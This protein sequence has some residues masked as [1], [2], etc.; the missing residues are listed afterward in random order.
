MEMPKRVYFETT[1]TIT[2]HSKGYIEIDTDFTQ[3]YDCFSKVSLRFKS[4]TS[5]KLMFWLLSH[6]AN[7]ANGI[8]SGAAVHERFCKFLKEEGYEEVPMRTFKAAF[9]ELYKTEVL[10]RVGRG[11]Y[12]FNPHVFW[13]NDKNERINFIIDEAKEKKFLSHNPLNET[14][15]LNNKP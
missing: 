11:Q 8:N 4:V 5:M 7:Q 1:E 13:R 10:T 12:Y 6:E 14:K 9:E 3:V 15:S 2:K